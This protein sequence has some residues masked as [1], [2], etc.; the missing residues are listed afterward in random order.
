MEEEAAEQVKMIETELTDRH[1]VD[2]ERR[3][4]VTVVSPL[5]FV[6]GYQMVQNR[7]S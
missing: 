1:S 4:R 3:Y 6:P 7:C 5:V 2:G